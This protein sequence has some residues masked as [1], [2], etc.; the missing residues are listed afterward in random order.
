MLSP[1][2]A[3]ERCWEWYYGSLR[4]RVSRRDLALA[5]ALIRLRVAALGSSPSITQL[6]TV[7]SALDLAISLRGRQWREMTRA[8][9]NF[10]YKLATVEASKPTSKKP[11]LDNLLELIS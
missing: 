7:R 2:T 1:C 5:D 10:P 4:S 6:Q 3:I 9:F 11:T 8:P